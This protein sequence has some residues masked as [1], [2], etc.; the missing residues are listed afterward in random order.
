MAADEHSELHI[1]WL[2]LK[3]RD[4]FSFFDDGIYFI[5]LL[6]LNFKVV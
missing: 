2:I 4:N 5:Y 3:S 1:H 6:Y